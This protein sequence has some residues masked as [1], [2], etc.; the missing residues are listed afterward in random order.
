M[1]RGDR[2]RISDKKHEY[3]GRTGTITICKQEKCYVQVD[4]TED[5]DE[6]GLEEATLRY[7]QVEP[8]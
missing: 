8:I 1:T 3:F 6:E 7:S 5:D 4:G 2:V